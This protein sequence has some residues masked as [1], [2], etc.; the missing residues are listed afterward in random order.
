MSTEKIINRVRVGNARCVC[1][2][3][4]VARS[5]SGFVSE[6]GVH[7]GARTYIKKNPVDPDSELYSQADALF[8]L[9][10]ENISTAEAVDILRKHGDT[11]FHTFVGS[12]FV[13]RRTVDGLTVVLGDY[14]FASFAPG[15]DVKLCRVQTKEESFFDM[16]K[17][18]QELIKKQ[19]GVESGKIV[20]SRP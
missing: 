20:G 1:H 2:G 9:W 8:R 16:K 13:G 3:H 6:F 17:Y 7:D 19:P 18:R 12:N 4:Y 15:G 14:V 10:N 11:M 5:A